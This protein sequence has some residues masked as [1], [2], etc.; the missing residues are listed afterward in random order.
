VNSFD[1]AVKTTVKAPHLE[2]TEALLVISSLTLVSVP[3]A[4]FGLVLR[5]GESS[6]LEV[7]RTDTSNKWLVGE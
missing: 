7:H 4:V 1:K 5:D 3:L 6:R 2:P